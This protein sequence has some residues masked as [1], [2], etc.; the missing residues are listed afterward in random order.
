MQPYF[1]RQKPRN[2]SPEELKQ[3]EENKLRWW[4]ENK[5]VAAWP[6]CVL[7]QFQAQHFILQSGSR[8][9]QNWRVQQFIAGQPTLFSFKKKIH[10]GYNKELPTFTLLNAARPLDESTITGFGLVNSLLSIPK[11]VIRSHI[12]VYLQDDPVALFALMLSCRLLQPICHNLLFSL[13]QR[14]FG[15]LGTPKAVM[16]AAFYEGS[17]PRERTKRRRTAQ[18]SKGEDE[19]QEEIS[20]DIL[21]EKLNL[22]ARDFKFSRIISSDVD[23]LIK[24]SIEKNGCIDN[25]RI[26]W[27]AKAQEVEARTRENAFVQTQ[28]ETRIEE[29]NRSLVQKGYSGLNFK[30]NEQK[31]TWGSNCILPILTIYESNS[32]YNA[33]RFLKN[34]ED[35]V[36]MRTE[37]SAEKVTAFV[38]FVQPVLFNIAFQN[39]NGDSTPFFPLLHL[40]IQM[41]LEI[42]LRGY[43]FYDRVMTEQE[44]NSRLSYI[45]SKEFRANHPPDAF[46][47]SG[48]YVCFWSNVDPRIRIYTMT[49]KEDHPTAMHYHQWLRPWDPS[50]HLRLASPSTG[51][52]YGGYIPGYYINIGVKIFMAHCLLTKKN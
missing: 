52:W 5:P 19:E 28:V 20:K 26:I 40:V 29:I 22:I 6:W 49:Q 38:R 10:L 2:A 33:R 45:F 51:Q 7:R 50:Y 39:M 35:Y 23:S 4:S 43:V 44:W 15:P 24:A 48:S 9:L 42:K 12:L 37:I 41:L 31:V 30:I 13:A 3:F 25:L 8:E 36:F 32:E 34:V 21:K 14:R 1:P 17:L 16:C 27:E 18:G 11:D 46:K 47:G